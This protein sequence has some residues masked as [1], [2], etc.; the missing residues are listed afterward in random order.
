MKKITKITL[1]AFAFLMTSFATF[2]QNKVSIV[3]G[4]H[5]ANISASGLNVD[6]L[7][8]QTIYRFTGGITYERKLDKLLSF[9]TGIIYKQKGFQLKE[10]T[11]VDIF[12]MALP[13]GV[14]VTSELNTI[15]VPLMLKVGFENKT[16][17]TPYLAAGPNL[18]YAMSGEIQTRATAIFDFVLTNVELDL[19]SENYN[20]LGIE[21]MIAGGVS[22]P[23]GNG[24]FKTEINY[25]H[26]LNNF[27]SN[28]FI[29]DTGLRN[30]GIGFNVG[31]SMKF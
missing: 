10:T 25:S 5:S 20:R 29:V 30:R 2:A 12:N 6:F 9:Q 23:Y 17:V 19:S 16:G 27:T 21:G 22:F 1:A 18:S 3:G 11:N 8:I 13:V 7:D 28:S 14:K 31:Y 26:A 24:E 15:D 4:I